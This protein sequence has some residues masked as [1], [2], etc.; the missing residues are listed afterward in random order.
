MNIDIVVNG[1]TVANAK[2]APGDVFALHVNGEPVA[3][4]L[5]DQT[6]LSWSTLSA[7]VSFTS[8]RL[9]AEAAQ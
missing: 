1:Q 6:I 3:G 5:A 7:M 9:S 2:L 4:V 8:T